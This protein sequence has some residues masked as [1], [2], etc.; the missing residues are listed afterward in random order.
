MLR[1]LGGG[2]AKALQAAA[3][4]RA[5]ERDKRKRE[6][7]EEAERAAKD[8]AREVTRLI[9]PPAADADGASNGRHQCLRTETEANEGVALVPL[10]ARPLHLGLEHVRSEVKQF[11][12][13]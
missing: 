12:A 8:S 10:P 3:H 11:I 7:K 5:G 4:K 13:C 9:H 6:Q 2:Q 1:E